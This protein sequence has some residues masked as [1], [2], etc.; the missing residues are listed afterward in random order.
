MSR[1]SE[2]TLVVYLCLTMVMYSRVCFFSLGIVCKSCHHTVRPVHA[3]DAAS[4]SPGR[5]REYRGMA[6]RVPRRREMVEGHVHPAVLVELVAVW[7]AR[8]AR[9][10]VNG[11]PPGIQQDLNLGM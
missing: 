8:K 5:G 10:N 2:A 4:A 11:P 3:C 9:T 6:E 7:R 1:H